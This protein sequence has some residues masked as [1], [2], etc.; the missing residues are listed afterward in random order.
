MGRLISVLIPVYNTGTFLSAAIDSLRAQTWADWE[1]VFV[2]DGSKDHSQAT[3][4]EALR[5]DARI[6]LICQRNAGICGARNRALEAMRG[7]AFVHMD[8]DDV[9]LP[10]T[11]ETFARAAEETGAPLVLGRM[12]TFEGAPPTPP[13]VPGGH[14]LEGEDWR[15]TIL[16]L[17]ADP[18]AEGM[19][20]PTWNKLYDRQTF[21]HFRCLPDSG[22]GDDTWYV[23]LTHLHARKAYV[24]DTVTYLWRRGH[25]SGSFGTCSP[26]WVRGYARALKAASTLDLGC[27]YAAAWGTMLHWVVRYAF[28][29]WTHSEATFRDP[30]FRRAM[31]EDLASLLN[32][33]LPLRARWRARLWLLKLRLWRLARMAYGHHR[34]NGTFFLAKETAT[35]G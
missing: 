15:R 30:A 7:D 34:A 10:W 12:Q 14:L 20:F 32:T 17:I 2:D 5:S 8:Q 4:A 29:A 26:A 18:Y 11:L 22:Y 28:Y 13:F 9:L 1:G 23:P 3:L 16:R 24:L 31:G 6:R 21:G 35:Q 33:A 19:N 27:D 25:I